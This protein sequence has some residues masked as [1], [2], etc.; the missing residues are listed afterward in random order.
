MTPDEAD[1]IEQRLDNFAAAILTMASQIG[2]LE[3]KV[4]APMMCGLEPRV[5]DVE[6]SRDQAKGSLGI[7]GYLVVT[8]VSAVMAGTVSLIIILVTGGK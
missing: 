7:I 6:S 8:A 1:R 4:H 5:R 3:A 2:S